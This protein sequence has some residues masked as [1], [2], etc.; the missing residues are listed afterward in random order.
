MHAFA[1]SDRRTGSALDSSTLSAVAVVAVSVSII[2]V[3]IILPSARG[4]LG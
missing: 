2:G 1:A 4:V 3:V